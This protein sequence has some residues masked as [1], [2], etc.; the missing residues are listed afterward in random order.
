MN[1]LFLGASIL[2]CY[3]R[4]WKLPIWRS[5][6][7]LQ[8]LL[9]MMVIYTTNH[10]P[11]FNRCWDFSN[12]SNSIRYL[13]EIL[14][15]WQNENLTYLSANLAGVQTSNIPFLQWGRE[16]INE[17]WNYSGDFNQAKILKIIFWHLFLKRR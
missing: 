14:Y 5:Y 17:W 11:I 9:T 13:M 8:N 1:F 16:E 4:V 7:F 10:L 12:N 3:G 2:P 6:N 15:Y